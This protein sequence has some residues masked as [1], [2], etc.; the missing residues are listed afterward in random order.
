M[1]DGQPVTTGQIPAQLRPARVTRAAFAKSTRQNV[2]RFA[3]K[4]APR[5][6]AGMPRKAR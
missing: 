3:T 5:H 1:S 2:K 4:A 6:R